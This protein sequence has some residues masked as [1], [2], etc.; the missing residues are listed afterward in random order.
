MSGFCNLPLTTAAELNK[1]LQESEKDPTNLDILNALAIGYFQ[2]PDQMTDKEHYDYFEKAYRL[3]KTVK[4]AHNFAWFL[5]FEWSEIEW[6]WKQDH[7]IERAIQIQKECIELHPK[8]FYPYYQYG[9]MLLHQRRYEEAIPF[10]EKALSLEE[11]RDIM[12]NIGYCYFQLE[13]FQQAKNFFSQSAAK[14]DMGNKGLYNLALTEWKLNNTAQVRS[15]ANL[16]AEQIREN[17]SEAVSGYETGFLYFLLGDLHQASA[18]L[19]KQGIDCIDLFEWSALSYSL[20]ITNPAVWKEKIRNG[21]DE[22]KKWCK[23]IIRNHK[24][25]N[26][27]TEDEKKERLHEL[28]DEIR[29]RQEALAKGIVHP[30]LNVNNWLTVEYCGCLLFDCKQHG[31][32]MD[33]SKAEDNTLRKP[34]T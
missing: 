15:I 1:L 17:I 14:Q 16:L 19:I 25:W 13:Q 31:I 9:Y 22:H 2:N 21:I 18:C 26:S 12:H 3:K 20:Y 28:E 34:D 30:T 27:Y 7:A 23:E 29:T 11:H 8:S 24:T 4:S 6:R 10:L 33:D 32:P 5:Y